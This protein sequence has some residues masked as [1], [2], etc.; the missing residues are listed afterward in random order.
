[1][2]FYGQR[3]V[4]AAWA[5]L[6]PWSIVFYLTTKIG[7][8]RGSEFIFG[9]NLFWAKIHFVGRPVIN[10]FGVRAQ[11]V[12]GGGEGPAGTRMEGR[13]ARSAL[14]ILV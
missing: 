8:T 4:T 11:G 3:S 1:M 10:K 12:S 14:N 13:V 5:T 9:Q 7:S 2:T 6:S